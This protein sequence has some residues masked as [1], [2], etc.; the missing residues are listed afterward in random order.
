MSLS[1]KIKNSK[2]TYKK[3][4]QHCK[5]LDEPCDIYSEKADP[6]SNTRNLWDHVIQRIE[7]SEIETLIVPNIFHISCDRQKMQAVLSLCEANHTKVQ[8]L[9]DQGGGL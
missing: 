6:N 3:L 4:I 1:E 8:F 9:D 5:G 7:S 2:N